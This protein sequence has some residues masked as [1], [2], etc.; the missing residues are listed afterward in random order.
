LKKSSVRMSKK[1][2]ICPHHKRP[3][4]LGGDYDFPNK[5]FVQRRIHDYWHTLAGDLDPDR[6]CNKL[7]SLPLPGKPEDVMLVCCFIG[8]KRS[9]QCTYDVSSR[10]IQK[11]QNAWKR[12]FPDLTFEQAIERINTT[13]LD[14]EYRLEIRQKPV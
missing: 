1:N 14:P 3:L 8:G 13:W 6:I 5:I 12:L 11:C 4:A 2:A 7:N 9:K 10:N